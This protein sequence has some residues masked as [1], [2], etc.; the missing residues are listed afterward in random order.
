MAEAAR[1]N[2]A[3]HVP[4]C[5]EW[6]VRELIRHTGGVHRF[7]GQ[8][9]EKA[10][11]DP[12]DGEDIPI[13]ESDVE[14]FTWFKE[15]VEWLAGVLK[16]LDPSRPNWSW[17]PHKTAGFVQR[18]MAQE[19]AVHRWDAELA[20]GVEQPIEPVLAGDGVSEMFDTFI[21]AEDTQPTGDGETILLHQTD[22]DGDW[23][24]R[25]TPSGLQVTAVHERGDAAVVG[26]GSNLLLALWGRKPLSQLETFG[27]DALLQKLVDYIDTD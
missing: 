8:V 2:L 18:R 22:G 19:T 26:T 16:D 14:L 4:S 13:P 12:K 25:F 27:N 11:N 23:L 5:P 10:L 6:N 21:P 3:A 9:A 17:S 1:N 24:V 15:G 20:A 7:W